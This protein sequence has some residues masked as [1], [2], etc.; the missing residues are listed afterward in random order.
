MI[1]PT[2]S[3]GVLLGGV[4]LSFASPSGADA[5]VR[6]AHVQYAQLQPEALP[7]NAGVVKG[8]VIDSVR[9][10]ALV[11]ATVLVIGM[12]LVA[13]TDSAGHFEID[14]VP[15][16][17]HRFALFHDF[18]DD[19]GV[20]ITTE[21]VSVGAA[22]TVTVRL[23]IPAAPT[24]VRTAC[25][26][27]GSHSGP[28]AVIGRVTD[29]ENESPVQ[30]ATVT[31]T[32]FEIAVGSSA[33]LRSTRQRSEAR[34]GTS[35]TY[36]FCGLPAEFSA[37]LF[38]RRDDVTSGEIPVAFGQVPLVVQTIRLARA[39]SIQVLS[40]PE[41]RAGAGDGSRSY[42]PPDNQR[43]NAV[44][45][46]RIVDAN[47][48]PIPKARV[49]VDGTASVGFTSDS[50]DFTLSGLPAGTQALLVRRLGFAP[51]E[52]PVEL[53]DRGTPPVTLRLEEYVPTLATV[54]IDR[55]LEGFYLRRTG[56]T[57]TFMDLDYI[58][59]QRAHSL[60]DLFR[61]IPGLVLT[62]NG[63]ERRSYA[64]RGRCVNFY[65]DGYL[66]QAARNEED[67]ADFVAPEE[68]A[69]LEAYGAGN[70]PAEFRGAVGDNP[71]AAVVMW[72]RVRH[73]TRLRPRTN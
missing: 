2:S 19:I 42:F 29:S 14:G 25:D 69:G 24:V 45:S 61:H 9:G 36:R 44:L 6:P 68:L 39:G 59:R 67:V 48:A 60:T 10:G 26:G 20:A 43:G 50:G 64:F 51:I 30:G 31:L 12:P 72:T 62:S 65:I 71:C 23:A 38:A 34:T 16:G 17:S 18:L 21:P 15:P 46:G 4:A 11:G 28:G 32:W 33:Q 54:Q 52:M 58:E 63:L 37:H 40:A 13:V 55:K 66:W 41:P 56:G 70:A 47:G 35:G 7:G 53:R 73:G 49:A 27:D 8:V 57:G 5:Q 1:H 3:F 22:D